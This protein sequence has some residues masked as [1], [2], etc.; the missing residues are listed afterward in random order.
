MHGG[1]AHAGW[2]DHIAPFFAESHRAIA[3]D[4]SGH[5]DSDFRDT[6]DLHTW[7]REVLA[8]AAASGASGLPTVV[9]HSMG[10]WVAARVA[11]Q[12]G[13]QVDAVVV[14]DSPL[15]DHAPEEPRLRRHSQRKPIHHSRE[16]LI[17]RFVPVP[18]QETVLPYVAHHIAADSV[19][20]TLRGWKWKFDRA[21]FTTPLLDDQ[22]ADQEIMER[23]FAEMPCRLAYLRC[24]AGLVPTDMAERIRSGMQLRGPFIELAEAGHHPM[25]DQPL[26]LVAALRTLLEM[27]SI[28]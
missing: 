7:A 27:W 14:I 17:A 8:A 22:R 5:G 10:G 16:E 3:L 20:R 21:V 26:P 23:I 18:S 9:G 24:E 12:Y 11:Q 1:A 25:L 2:W 4:L 13:E 6:Y 19:R 15:R 28:T